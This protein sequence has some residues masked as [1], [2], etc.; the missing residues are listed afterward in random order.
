MHA[1]FSEVVD[2]SPLL[3]RKM[4]AHDSQI[5]PNRSV[6]KELPHQS[7]PVSPG[8]GEQQNS[9][10]KTVDAVNSKDRLPTIG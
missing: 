9:R 2:Q 10:R 5:S 6:S 7:V 4:S 8:L 1:V 3:I